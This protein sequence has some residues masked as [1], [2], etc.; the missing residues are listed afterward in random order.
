MQQA[1]GKAEARLQIGEDAPAPGIAR[2]APIS[3][4]LQKDAYLV[5][6]ALCKLS[7]RAAEG[8]AGADLTVLRG[9]VCC[10][11]LPSLSTAH[12]GCDRVLHKTWE[13]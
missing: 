13:P 4:V 9:K 11:P 1:N 2:G 3:S 8:T 7:I 10:C 5:F 6:R 12:A